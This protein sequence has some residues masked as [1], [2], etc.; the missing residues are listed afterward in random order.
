MAADLDGTVTIPKR[1]AIRIFG[2]L[3]QECA[4]C[5]NPECQITDNPEQAI[6]E[7]REQ[8]WAL[9]TGKAEDNAGVGEVH[10]GND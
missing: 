6:A 5:A 3:A 10:R 1:L 2:L 7:C 9:F 8:L 4:P